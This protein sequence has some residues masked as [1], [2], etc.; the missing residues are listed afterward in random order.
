[1]YSTTAVSEFS[2]HYQKLCSRW[3]SPV[4]RFSSGILD[5]W[6]HGR[7]MLE[8]QETFNSI[9]DVSDSRTQSGRQMIEGLIGLLLELQQKAAAT[10][11]QDNSHLGGVYPTAAGVC[12]ASTTA[13]PLP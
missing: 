13:G 10:P 7:A 2:Q 4:P 8:V 6:G 1:L 9:L 5:Q 12:S 3:I 11:L